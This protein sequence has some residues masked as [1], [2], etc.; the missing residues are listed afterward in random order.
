MS[1]FWPHLHDVYNVIN[2]GEELKAK[3]PPS[4]WL[5]VCVSAMGIVADGL[6]CHLAHY[7]SASCKYGHQLK[8]KPQPATTVQCWMKRAWF[9][10]IRGRGCQT[11]VYGEKTHVLPPC[12]FCHLS[13]F[14]N[15]FND[16]V[17]LLGQLWLVVEVVIAF[18]SG[19]AGLSVPCPP[20]HCTH[21]CLHSTLPWLQ[22]PMVCWFLPITC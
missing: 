5:C 14:T 15:L 12:L 22:S 16:L 2:H 8:L 9:Q 4:I 18:G 7:N 11:L 10:R 20:A 21:D 3:A 6:S 1:Q 13:C 17:L 19:V